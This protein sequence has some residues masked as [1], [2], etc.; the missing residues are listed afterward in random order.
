MFKV[1]EVESKIREINLLIDLQINLSSC[2]TTDHYFSLSL[3][4]LSCD[5]LETK[6]LSSAHAQK[7]RKVNKSLRQKVHTRNHIVYILL[8]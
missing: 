5:S 1:T 4:R 6:N 2:K 8:K 3:Q 7:F